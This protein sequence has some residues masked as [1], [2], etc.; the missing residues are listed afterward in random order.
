MDVDPDSGGGLN[1]DLRELI[2]HLRATLE[3][4]Q[5]ATLSFALIGDGAPAD[6]I[7]A[8]VPEPVRDLLEVADGIDAG[9][10]TLA[11]TGNIAYRQQGLEI[12]PDFTGVAAE[13]G[14]WYYLGTLSQEP[15][16][17]RRDTGAVW[18]FPQTSTDAY[19]AREE[20]EEA[21][22]NLE[23]FLVYY[24]FG[25]GYADVGSDHDGW[26]NFLDEHE[27]TTVPD[28]EDDDKTDV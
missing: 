19:Y 1:P 17:L 14:E 20:F 11:G 22:P 10:F 2:E 28:D 24:V 9:D 21:M 26:W 7:P 8:E 3:A 27:L 4:D 5:P 16:L 13:P 23:Y 18:W 25:P 6:Q 12:M 15:V